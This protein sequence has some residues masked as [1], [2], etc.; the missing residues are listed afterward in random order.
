MGSGTGINKVFQFSL[1]FPNRIVPLLRIIISN[2]QLAVKLKR[3]LAFK[4]QVRFIE[5]PN[6][7]GLIVQ[8]CYRYR[9]DQWLYQQQPQVPGTLV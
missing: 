4:E 1:F 3:N 6:T 7:T 2:W 9:T 5:Q 8:Q